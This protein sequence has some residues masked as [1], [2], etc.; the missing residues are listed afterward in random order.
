MLSP[1]TVFVP[2]ADGK[3]QRYFL[4][5]MESQEKCRY[6]CYTSDNGCREYLKIGQTSPKAKKVHVSHE[7]T[8]AEIR[9]SPVTIFNTADA[10]EECCPYNICMH[11]SIDVV[12]EKWKWDLALTGQLTD[13]I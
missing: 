6:R 9:F 10:L 13:W 1:V 5:S 2:V 8:F 4:W 3:E 7:R 12:K 11:V